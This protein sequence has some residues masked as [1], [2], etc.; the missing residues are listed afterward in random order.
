MLV[1]MN[2]LLSEVSG[3]LAKPWAHGFS[4]LAGPLRSLIFYLLGKYSFPAET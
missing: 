3:E 2:P 1:L 4:W